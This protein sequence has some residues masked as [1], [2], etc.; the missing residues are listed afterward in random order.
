MKPATARSKLPQPSKGDIMSR[1][2]GI[3]PAPESGFPFGKS[4]LVNIS[5][6]NYPHDANLVL[7]EEKGIPVVRY[8]VG[9][10]NK[11]P[12]LEQ[13]VSITNGVDAGSVQFEFTL[14]FPTPA[15][16]TEGYIAGKYTFSFFPPGQTASSFNGKL[17]DPH[18]PRIEGEDD[19]WIAKGTGSDDEDETSEY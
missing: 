4:F 19:D 7:S 13:I 12:I 16:I 9:S 17:K 14:D 11:S 6:G 15:Q 18:K 5:G 8:R 1:P 3:A 10:K 2:R